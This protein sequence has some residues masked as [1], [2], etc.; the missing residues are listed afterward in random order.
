MG[1]GDDGKSD[2]PHDQPATQ[3]ISHNQSLQQFAH[4][5]FGIRRFHVHNLNQLIIL[6]I[7][8]NCLRREFNYNYQSSPIEGQI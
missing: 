8:G 5:K 2:C 7:F 1:S 4:K 3:T 6:M